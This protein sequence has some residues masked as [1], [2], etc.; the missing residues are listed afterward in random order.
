MFWDV[1]PSEPSSSNFGTSGT[2]NCLS[3]SRTRR[4]LYCALASDSAPPNMGPKLTGSPGTVGA[5][6]PCRPA[7]SLSPV[8]SADMERIEGISAGSGKSLAGAG[9][10]R[11]P[12]PAMSGKEAVAAQSATT[13]TSFL[14]THHESAWLRAFQDG[15][16][17]LPRNRR[18]GHS[19]SSRHSKTAR[20]PWGSRDRRA[21]LAA[22]ER[23]APTAML[24]YRLIVGWFAQAGCHACRLPDRP[25]YCAKKALTQKDR[26]R[27]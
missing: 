19:R 4:R 3:R 17:E 20:P 15:Q 7:R 8:R 23:T 25:W 5:G 18:G 10:R 26:I 2:T 16:G 14:S 21:G 13:R 9:L 27:R 1:H 24:L 11:S 6:W 22:V 12:S